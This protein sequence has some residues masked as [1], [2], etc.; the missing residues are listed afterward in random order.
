MALTLVW[1]KWVIAIICAALA[2]ELWRFAR[3]RHE[4]L[5]ASL[6]KRVAVFVA[7]IGL[8]PAVLGR[9]YWPAVIDLLIVAVVIVAG[10][11]L[12]VWGARQFPHI[13]DALQERQR[14]EEE[15]EAANERLSESLTLLRR[16]S[17]EL[18][19]LSYLGTLL[20]RSNTVEELATMIARAA[21]DLALSSSGAVFLFQHDSSTELRWTTPKPATAGLSIA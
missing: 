9:A 18:D 5:Y 16:R 21:A 12:V 6:L 11:A 20:Q 17:R 10:G 4:G 14:S 15:L 8:L 3:Q 13:L 7:G 1:A 2:F 19:T